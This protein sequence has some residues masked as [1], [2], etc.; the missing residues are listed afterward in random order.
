MRYVTKVCYQLYRYEQRK[1][2]LRFIFDLF[3]TMNRI[4]RKKGSPGINLLWYCEMI[5]K[6]DKIFTRKVYFMAFTNRESNGKNKSAIEP[7]KIMINPLWWYVW[8]ISKLMNVFDK[9]LPLDINTNSQLYQWPFYD[10]A[11]NRSSL[12]ISF[13]QYT[14]NCLHVKWVKWKR[15]K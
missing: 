7:H 8:L 2:L 6:T 9:Y 1:I 4:C 5:R 12:I 10:C 3:D 14:P 13:A 15:K 11:E